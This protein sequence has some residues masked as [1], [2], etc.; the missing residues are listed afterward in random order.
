MGQTRGTTIVTADLFFAVAAPG[1]G[2]AYIACCT[3]LLRLCR[4][5]TGGGTV[6]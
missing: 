1:P 3:L 6:A 2:R 4:E 5:N